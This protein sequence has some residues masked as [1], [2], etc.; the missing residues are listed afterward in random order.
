MNIRTLHIV[1]IAA[2]T[3]VLK[4]CNLVKL[5]NQESEISILKTLLKKGQEEKSKP[6]N[7]LFEKSE[8]VQKEDK[9]NF[10]SIKEPKDIELTKTSSKSE[11]NAFSTVK[12]KPYTTENIREP[13]REKETNSSKPIHNIIDDDINIDANVDVDINIHIN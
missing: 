7:S 3:V 2:M 5:E 6:N 10:R 12:G 13:L 4:S 9:R 1:S 8:E 11:Y